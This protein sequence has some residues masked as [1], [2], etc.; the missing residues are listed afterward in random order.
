MVRLGRGQREAHRGTAEGRVL[1][2]DAA[3]EMLDDLAAD[4]EAETGALG[5]VLERA[6]AAADLAELLEDRLAIGCGTPGPL[7]STGHVAPPDRR[8]S[9]ITRPCPSGTNLAALASRLI[10]HLDH[11]VAVGSARAH[12]PG[13]VAESKRHMAARRTGLLVA[14]TASSM[15]SRRGSPR[16]ATP[17]FQFDLGEIE[18]IVDQARQPLQF[19]DDDARKRAA[20]LRLDVGSRRISENERIEVKGRAQLVADRGQELVLE[21]VDLAAGARWPRAARPWHASS[22]WDFC[23]SWRLYSIAREVSSRICMQIVLAD[24]LAARDRAHH[25]PGRGRADRARELALGELDQHRVRRRV[26][27]EHATAPPQIARKDGIGPPLAE[28]SDQQPS[29]RRNLGLAAPQVARLLLFVDVDEQHRLESGRAP[30]A[31]EQAA[32]HDQGDVEAQAPDQGV[33]DGAQA[34]HPE[35]RLGPQERHAH[36]PVRDEPAVDQAGRRQ[37]RQ[38]QGVE[39]DRDAAAQA[40]QGAP[41]LASFQ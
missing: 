23:S 9:T 36:R 19:P 12:R 11:A 34:L 24:H 33:A 41:R 27:R 22:A 28:E 25:H 21:L 1:G 16:H 37:G 14:L 30:L 35:Q 10:T 40:E 20:V 38:N 13:P 2:P 3:A 6:A 32:E 39:P 26:G 18:E 17:S 7:S 8:I 15:I 4:R 29:Q 5:L 31:P